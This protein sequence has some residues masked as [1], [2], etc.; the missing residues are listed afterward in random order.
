MPIVVRIRPAMFT[1]PASRA[2]LAATAAV[3][4]LVLVG[5]HHLTPA[6]GISR[7]R[8]MLAPRRMVALLVD[9][10]IPAIERA[11]IEE[12]L[13][14]GVIPLLLSGCDPPPAAL[15]CWLSTVCQDAAPTI[16]PGDVRATGI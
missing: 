2:R 8:R 6:D 7:L 4:E 11:L 5:V 1:Q 3:H 12:L 10:D 16:T 14:D 13:N 15:T 9:G